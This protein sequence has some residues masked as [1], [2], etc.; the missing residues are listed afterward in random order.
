MIAISICDMCRHLWKDKPHH[1]C[2]VY[3]EG[4]TFKECFPYADEECGNGYKFEPD[5]KSRDL[6][7]EQMYKN[8]SRPSPEDLEWEVSVGER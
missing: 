7:D 4:R 1:A 3:P 5:D 8:F 2:P 6:W